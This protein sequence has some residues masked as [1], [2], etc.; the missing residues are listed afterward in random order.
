MFESVYRDADVAQRSVRARLR[1]TTTMSGL[2][3]LPAGVIA[4]SVAPA[5]A[6][7]TLERA[8]GRWTTTRATIDP[9]RFRVPLRPLRLLVLTGHISASVAGSNIYLKVEAS[10]VVWIAAVGSVAA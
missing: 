5:D 9:A 4:A 7:T 3:P 10:R 8:I 1:R 6:A 2:A